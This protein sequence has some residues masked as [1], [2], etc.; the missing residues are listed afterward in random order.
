MTRAG[1]AEGSERHG[2]LLARATDKSALI[3]REVREET[4][5]L[6]LARTRVMLAMVAGGIVTALL[7]FARLHI[8]GWPLHP[9]GYALMGAFTTSYLWLP[10]WI[11]C[12]IKAVI[13]RYGGLRTYRLGM[14]FFLGLL[15]GEFV[16]GGGW[17]LL[18]VLTGQRLYVFWPY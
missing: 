16:V 9:V 1:R 8:L 5:R 15:L 4:D 10:L 13:V 2:H 18:S 11:S 12:A 17:A 14:S 3:E 6:L 7:T